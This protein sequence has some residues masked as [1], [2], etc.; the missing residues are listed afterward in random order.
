MLQE[1]LLNLRQRVEA[2][3]RD[4]GYKEACIE[5]YNHTWDH[6]R[7]FMSKKGVTLYTRE[8]GESFLVAR[9]GKKS[10]EGLT[11]R[12]QE[13]VRHIEVLTQ[14]LETGTVHR[15]RVTPKK[16]VFTGPEGAL[17]NQFLSAETEYKRSSSVQRYEERLYNLYTFLCEKHIFLSD[18]TPS[19]LME[20]VSHLDYVK[21]A[22]DRDNIM[23]QDFVSREARFG[24]LLS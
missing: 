12:Q 21:S 7:V 8:L 23:L 20:Y 11:H 22:P 3:L 15:S 24:V 10:F 5:R 16:I 13:C 9:Y 6:L 17:F 4:K 2:L 1:S 19:V 18:M 14:M